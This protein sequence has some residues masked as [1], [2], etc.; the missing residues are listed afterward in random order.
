M[1]KIFSILLTFVML[2]YLSACSQSTPAENDSEVDLISIAEEAIEAG[3]YKQ[4]YS[5]LLKSESKEAADL[6]QNFIFM[7]ISKLEGNG[8]KITYTYDSYGNL[9]TEESVGSSS[10]EKFAYTYD[11][12]KRLSY[13]ATNSRGLFCNVSYTYDKY[14]KL[15]TVQHDDTYLANKDGGALHTGT[16]K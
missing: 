9:L 4:A 3:D 10:W 7:P 2:M 5:L 11:S 12:S 8:I 15:I 6:L 14:G 1:N 13:T 16:A